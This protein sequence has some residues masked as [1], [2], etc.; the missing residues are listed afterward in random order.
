VNLNPVMSP[1]SVATVRF[2]ICVLPLLV[3]ALF[4]AIIALLALPMDEQRRNYALLVA[5][6][7]T[8][9]AAVLV[10]AQRSRSPTSKATP[11]EQSAR[12]D[13]TSTYPRP[14]D[15]APAD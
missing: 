8:K 1:S 14:H 2:V 15:S 13:A 11:P 12:S 6:H 10:G 7:L 4:V 5:D 9:F 3:V